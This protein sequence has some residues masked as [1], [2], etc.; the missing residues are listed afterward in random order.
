MKMNNK[1][2]EMLKQFWWALLPSLL[3]AVV[4]G[5]QWWVE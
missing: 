4:L 2:K 1:Q 5:H 3:F